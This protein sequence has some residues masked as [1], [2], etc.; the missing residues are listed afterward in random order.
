MD[1]NTNASKKVF[2]TGSSGLIGSFLVSFLLKEG[3]RVIPLSRKAFSGQGDSLGV[4]IL[5][6]CYAVIHLAGESIAEGVWTA[7]KKRKILNSRVEGTQNLV[8]IIGSLENPPKVFISAS[9]VGFYG[10]R[11]GELTEESSAGQGFLSLVCKKWEEAPCFL[12]K[13]EVRVV[14]ARFGYILSAK[15]GML[16]ALLPVFRL[17]LGGKIGSGLQFMPWI[18]IED[19][20]RALCHILETSEL[21]GPVNIVSPNPVC[22]EFF[23]KTLASLLKR[24]SFFTIP[25]WI[26]LGEKAKALMLPSLRVI[27]V[28]LEKTGFTF[29]FSF[30]K[31]ALQFHLR[32]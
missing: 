1:F 19:V 31:E 12:E 15:G 24:P 18:A 8:K 4:E 30:L 6:G 14:L 29:R 32:K 25:K 9:A 2:I 16:K 20:A 5:E 7:H 27:P 13:K 3:Y 11:E 17:G 23:A 28:K 21:K 26:L 22:Q 10:D